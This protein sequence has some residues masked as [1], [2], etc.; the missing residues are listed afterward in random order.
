[1]KTFDV[2]AVEIS[3]DF[4]RA[5]RYIA[6]PCNLP[7]WTDAFRSAGDGKAVLATPAGAAEIELDVRS[8]PDYGAIDWIMRFP[9]Q[10]IERA[11]SRLVRAGERRCIF[12][13]V[14]MAPQLPLEQ[15][16]GALEQQSLTLRRELD[17]L[18]RIL[19]G[20]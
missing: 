4:E 9:D 7:E 13:F 10:T 15:L 17:K 18:R 5:F 12:S 19:G 11:Y 3:A 14:L 6:E 16:E 8:S 2:Q 1:M 20:A